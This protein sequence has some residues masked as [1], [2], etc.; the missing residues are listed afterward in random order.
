[1][2]KIKIYV[3]TLPV[4]QKSGGIKTFLLELLNALAATK[5][6]QFEYYIICS[7]IT[8]PIFLKFEVFENYKLLVVNTDHRSPLKRILFEQFKLTAILK[9]KT[10]TI[11]LN[12]C[13]TAN[14][15]YTG[16]F[17]YPFLKKNIAKG[18]YIIKQAAQNLLRFAGNK[19][20]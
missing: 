10:N 11:L 8:K 20:N 1:M 6:E 19:I 15:N 7:E 18:I 16:A 3:N 9:N 17:K 2:Q 5:D 13:C 14:H 4:T 12:M